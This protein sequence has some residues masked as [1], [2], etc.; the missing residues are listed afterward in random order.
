MAR[1][2]KHIPQQGERFGRFVVVRSGDPEID[3]KTKKKKSRYW[4]QCD[5][6]SDVKLVRGASLVDGSIQSCGCLH[7]EVFSEIL[8]E[9]THGK[10]YNNYDL[11]G[12]YGLG[13]TFKNE[14]FYFDLEDY[15]KIKDICWYFNTKGYVVGHDTINT[16]KQI[17]MH[18]LILPTYDGCVA[19]HIDTNA[20]N[21]NRKMNLRIATQEENTRNRKTPNNNTSGKTGVSFDKNKTKWVAYIGYNK[22]N[23]YLGSF[24]SYQDAVNARTEAEDKYFG[25]F[26]YTEDNKI[27]G[28]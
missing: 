24:V 27:K 21:D 5:C 6:G 12:E 1:K 14:V 28:E 20:K 9:S 25:E 16:K 7:N 10:K 4:C 17:K 19:D 15:D 26:K 13:Y 8:S 18:Q 11:S 22:Q 23:I 3:P 2:P